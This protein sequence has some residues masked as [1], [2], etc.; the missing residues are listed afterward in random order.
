MDEQTVQQFWQRH[1]CGDAQVGG[2][3]ER[4][5]DDYEKFFTDYDR[6]RYHN[7][8]HLPACID[9]LEVAGKQVLEV[10][11]GE[12]SESERLIRRGARWSGVDLTAESVARVRARL[13]LRELPYE[14]LR[15][16]SVLDL[17][18]PDGSFDLVFS[19]G[20]L[21]HVP[22]IRQAQQ[23]IHR[24]LRPGGELVIMMYARWSLNYL[25]SIAV[26]RRAVLLAAYPLSRAG[27]LKS[28]DAQGMLASHL[29][30]A[31][32]KGLLR[33]LR[34]D[35]FVH[36]NTD[37]PANPYAL[38]YDRRRIQRDFPC[39]RITRSYKRFMHSP[40]FPVHRLPGQS[41]LGWHLWAHLV[42]VGGG[43]QSC[44]SA[45]TQR[46]RAQVL[47]DGSPPD[48]MRVAINLLT[49]N[50]EHPSGA[51][52][53]WTRMIP[54]MARQLEAH[55]ELHLLVSPKSRHLYQ[56]YGPR[57]RYITYPWSNERRALR[58]LSEHLYSP[59][60][61]R[62]S[63]IDVFN[64]LMAPLMSISWSL[65]IHMKTMHAFTAPDSL[66]PLARA[67]R[68]MNYPRS[69]RVADAIIINSES[70]R[71]EIQRYL[72]V[73]ARKLKLI[74]EAVDHDLFKPGDAGAARA[75]IAAHGVTKPFVLFVSSLWPYK[76][77]D[78]L[79]RAWALARAE[80]GDRQLAIVGAGRDEKYV[81]ALHALAAELGIAAD[82]VFVGGVPLDETVCFYQ[83]ADA[84]VYPS[85]NETFGLPILEAMACGCPVVTSDTSA[86]PET[87]GG[88]AL[89][90]DPRD[91]A[92]IARAL[93]EAATPGRDRL[94]DAGLK[95]ASQFT[96][97]ATA[98]STLD[99]Y[100]EVA[101]RRRHRRS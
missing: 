92:S 3:R 97:G 55:E 95:R 43:G 83:A 64:T 40:P 30:S 63:N 80:L 59:P 73:D 93:V 58:T 53:F 23:E 27:I 36:H 65:V 31:K 77:C 78:G 10:G 17:P 16:A 62:L 91:P 11:L 18:F 28:G 47:R 44:S 60:R 70:L 66:T 101:E 61:L 51:H 46:A 79:L 52:W 12:G 45:T 7:E 49:E 37:G 86:M 76:N 71:G 67:Y 82:V 39:F 54:E 84:F 21:H 57:V 1:A 8:R 35:E 33:Y 2:L 85:F 25:V 32:A 48:R 100:R 20:V 99:V 68:R 38:V 72:E 4:F 34:L 96:W 13:T 5:G 75:R 89:L 90:S 81:G 14:Q 56:G 24:V 19:H 15:Q 9:A 50:P 6:F 41:V 94:R 69:A 22:E 88:A 42:P 29:A 98:A 87:A 74:Y 26:V